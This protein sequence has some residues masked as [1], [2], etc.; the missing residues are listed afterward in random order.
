MRSRAQSGCS[1]GCK[2]ALSTNVLLLEF[3]LPDGVRLESE[4]L[5][6]LAVD[7]LDLIP[8][9]GVALRVLTFSIADL[10]AL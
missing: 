8:W 1:G 3:A 6:R 7:E 5:D 2:A 9:N 4:T 10:A